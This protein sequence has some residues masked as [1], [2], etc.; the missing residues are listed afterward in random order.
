MVVSVEK[1]FALTGSGPTGVILLA[2]L[3]EFLAVLQDADTPPDATF[4]ADCRFRDSRLTRLE[5]K[6]PVG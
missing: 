2:D 6:P 1:E 4:E 3:R 5:L